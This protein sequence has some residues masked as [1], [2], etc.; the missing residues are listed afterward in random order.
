[1]FTDIEIEYLRGQRIARLATAQP[2]GTLQ[3]NPVGFD[4][5]TELGTIDIGG[6][7][8]TR[9]RKF[10]NVAANGQA[11]LV[12]DDLASVDPWRPR[13]LEIR[14]RAEAIAEPTDASAQVGDPTAPIIRLHPTR[15]L[16]LG[17]H[18]GDEELTPYET[19]LHSRT[20]P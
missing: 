14:G 11:A 10:R 15:I 12:V 3:N 18:P 5:N 7:R 4:V 2:S 16:S 19:E 9:S 1:V 20:V 13:F 17:L 8:L 6:Y